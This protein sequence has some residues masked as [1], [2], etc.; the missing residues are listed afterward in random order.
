VRGSRDYGHV[1]KAMTSNS[2]AE[3]HSTNRIFCCAAE[4]DVYICP[5]GER[6]AY[7]YTNEE[8]E[9]LLS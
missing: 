5:A 7:H 2:K 8:N 4:Q 3:G 9:M 1:A 6:L